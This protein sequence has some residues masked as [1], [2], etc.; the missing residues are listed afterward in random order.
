MKKQIITLAVAFFAALTCLRADTSYL[1]IQGAFGPGG[2]EETF[3]WAVTYPTGYAIS[4]QD[5]L[6]AV[7]GPATLNGTYSDDFGGTFPYYTAG[8]GTQGASYI[9]F[10]GGFGAPFLASVT[11]N[12]TTVAQDTSYNSTW[13]YYVAG[14]GSNLGNGYD[15]S[16]AWTF[17]QD[18]S[19]VRTPVDGSFDAW[20]FGPFGVTVDGEG[21]TPTAENFAGAT[22]LSIPEPGST[23]L[24]LVGA[25]G[26]LAYFKKRRA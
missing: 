7:F 15:N 18:G 1:L 24:L 23:T 25:G 16:G 20:V 5:L 9:D 10:A 11:L 8:N 12:S 14:G 21:N 26:L 2:T 4:G 22:A 6:T 19:L 3:K 17:S 13:S